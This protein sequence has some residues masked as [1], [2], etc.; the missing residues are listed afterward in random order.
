MTLNES[1][2]R[3]YLI[4]PKLEAIGWGRDYVRR[5]HYYRRDVQYTIIEVQWEL[6]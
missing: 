5:E 3:A 2:T 1:D 4:D 6:P